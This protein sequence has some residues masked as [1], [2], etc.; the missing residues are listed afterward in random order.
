[1]TDSNTNASE[2][3]TISYT[4]AN[5][6]LSGSGLTLGA[7]TN[8][9]ITDTLTASSASA[10]QQ[11]LQRLVF[12]PT[13][14]QVAAGQTVS[15]AFTLSVTDQM[16][17]GYQAPLVISQ[18]NVW[19]ITGN[20][21]EK[22]SPIAG[23]TNTLTN[24]STSITDTD[25]DTAIPP[26]LS[27]ASYNASIG[28][29]SLTGTHLT[30]SLVLSDLTLKAGNQSF[31]LNTAN[32]SLGNSTS[33]GLNITLNAHDQA[34]VNAMFNTNGTASGKNT[35]TL[36]TTKGWDSGSSVASQQT[37]TVSQDRF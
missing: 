7:V 29:L 13:A 23:V 12:T 19:V 11:E 10:L 30:A 35:Y 37:V 27:A 5:G 36:S 17:S 21:V 18:G 26:V 8:G 1:M 28:T 20:N 22:F 9:T 4:A 25:T 34:I 32:D 14:H 15:T 24:S 16:V 3:V 31:T 6:T 33:T 2:T